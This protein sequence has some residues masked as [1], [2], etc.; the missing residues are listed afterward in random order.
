MFHF[1][2]K[3]LSHV[4]IFML[5]I[6][7]CI[8]IAMGFVRVPLEDTFT[9]QVFLVNPNG[10][11]YDVVTPIDANLK[12]DIV[13]PGII[14]G[15][16]PGVAGRGVRLEFTGNDV[17]TLRKLGVPTELINS[18]GREMSFAEAFCS[19]H[20]VEYQDEPKFINNFNHTKDYNFYRKGYHII[21]SLDW[22][23]KTCGKIHIATSDFD[24]MQLVMDDIN[25]RTFVLAQLKRDSHINFIQ[26]LI[27]K[28]RFKE[29]MIYFAGNN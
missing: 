12:L 17:D 3:K 10:N 23:E 25:N 11:G 22:S 29:N 8:E 20:K 2:R 21:T 26:R 24:N 9:G 7:F 5:P 1:R 14:Y 18:D 15:R 4:V 13:I 16:K 27:L 28:F 19:A 6:L